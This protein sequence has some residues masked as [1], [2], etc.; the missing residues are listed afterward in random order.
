MG[1]SSSGATIGILHVSLPLGISCARDPS[2]TSCPRSCR[3]H[4][5]LRSY[6]LHML[7]IVIWISYMLYSWPSRSVVDCVC[8]V[9]RS[10]IILCEGIYPILAYDIYQALC[11]LGG[12]SRLRHRQRTTDFI[13]TATCARREN[14]LLSSR[15]AIHNKRYFANVTSGYKLSYSQAG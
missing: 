14:V 1:M 7:N 8:R 12:P 5:Y 11:S 15:T 10:G 13:Y 3:Y 2:Y 6:L 9:T 4:S